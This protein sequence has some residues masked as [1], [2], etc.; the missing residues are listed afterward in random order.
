M[1]RVVLTINII[2]RLYYPYLLHLPSVIDYYGGHSSIFKFNPNN[3][4]NRLEQVKVTCPLLTVLC[5]WTKLFLCSIW[6]FPSKEDKIKIIETCIG[7]LKNNIW[8]MKELLTIKEASVY[9]GIA[10]SYLY[11]LTSAKKIPHYKPNGKLVY[12]KRKELY[13]WAIQNQVIPDNA[14]NQLEY[15]NY[16]QE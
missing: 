3:L 14:N 8:N 10:K 5:S 11:K 6:I 9:L 12:F 16:E 7:V 1:L 15:V 4:W 2:N 13:D